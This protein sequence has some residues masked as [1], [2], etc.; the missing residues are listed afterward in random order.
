MGRY[1][2]E[3][4]CSGFWFSYSSYAMED[5]YYCCE[6][7]SN[8]RW[9]HCIRESRPLS[10]HTIIKIVYT[11]KVFSWTKK[12]FKVSGSFVQTFCI[13]KDSYMDAI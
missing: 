9:A 1:N 2:E 10:K 5:S 3:N 12:C 4:M 6:L 11:T 13:E 7:N 8:N